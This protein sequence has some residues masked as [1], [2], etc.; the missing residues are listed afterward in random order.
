MVSNRIRQPKSTK[1]W[2]ECWMCPCSTSNVCRKSQAWNTSNHHSFLSD[3]CILQRFWKW[4]SSSCGN[5]TFNMGISTFDTYSLLLCYSTLDT[6][7][8]IRWIFHSFRILKE[9]KVM[10]VL[11]WAVPHSYGPTPLITRMLQ[12][13]FHII[14]PLSSP[15][16]NVH[17]CC[18]YM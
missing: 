11:V 9:M 5:D 13:P 8:Y 17:S 4:S 3:V 15:K 12:T 10:N 7:L 2:R 18:V 14:P 1:G 16:I 6:T